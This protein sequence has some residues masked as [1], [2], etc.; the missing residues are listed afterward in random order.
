MAGEMDFYS[1]L[2]QLTNPTH[3]LGGGPGAGNAAAMAQLILGG[4]K[5]SVQGANGQ[6]QPIMGPGAQPQAAPISENLKSVLDTA[7][8]VANSLGSAHGSGAPIT[9][10]LLP[11]PYGR[12]SYDATDK[13]AIAQVQAQGKQAQQVDTARTFIKQLIG[14]QPTIGQ[15]T[16]DPR[17]NAY[18]LA[19]YNQQNDAYKTR[20]ASASPIVRGILENLG[21]S[22][23]N[24]YIKAYNRKKGEVDA[25]GGKGSLDGELFRSAGSKDFP[26]KMAAAIAEGTLTQN[27]IIAAERLHDARIKNQTPEEK[28]VTSYENAQSSI[29]RLDRLQTKYDA[30]VAD[31]SSFGKDFK[32]SMA[33]NAT[34]AAFLDHEKIPFTPKMT[35]AERSFVT[36]LNSL[37]I[38]MRQMYDDQRMSDQDVQN[39]LKA[40][41]DP[42]TGP[43]MFK[44]QLDATKQVLVDRGNS[45]LQSM[46]VRGK[47]ISGLTG[48]QPQ[49][50]APAGKV[51]MV[52]PNGQSGYV[53]EA[54][55]AEA[56]KQG[57]KRK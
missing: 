48:V 26:E 54:Q 28:L 16:N 33:K 44:S 11:N 37:M 30:A 52:N 57:Y 19:V 18:D 22:G 10:T 45:L 7:D 17:Q 43:E 20:V 47:D 53:P 4:G 51:L 56:E 1:V 31:G 5:A 8:Q 49:G 9:Q 41:G 55:A 46:K 42:K 14:E 35:D 40:L 27:Q 23:E 34:F 32:L 25:K 13:D 2:E 38:G 21:I 39:F 6:M 15:M 36:E 3:D 24:D 50:K 12:G 29:G